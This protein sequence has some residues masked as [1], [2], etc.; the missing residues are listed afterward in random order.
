[1]AYSTPFATIARSATASRRG[2]DVADRMAGA[3]GENAIV[4]A[5]S[6]ARPTGAVADERAEVTQHG[7]DGPDDEGLADVSFT[8]PYCSDIAGDGSSDGAEAVFGSSPLESH[9]DPPGCS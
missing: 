2:S 9:R 4:A 6:G 3:A 5:A 8:A 1:M 7:E